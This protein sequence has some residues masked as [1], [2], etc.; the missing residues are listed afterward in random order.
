MVA[1]ATSHPWARDLQYLT[2]SKKKNINASVLR[3]AIEFSS[4]VCALKFGPYRVIVNLTLLS[5]KRTH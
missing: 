3:G 1:F 4:N 2:K 5:C